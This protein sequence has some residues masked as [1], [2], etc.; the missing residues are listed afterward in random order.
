[1][2][3]I[4]K[5]F[6]SSGGLSPAFCDRLRSQVEVYHLVGRSLAVAHL[7]AAYEDDHYVYMV[8]ELCTGEPLNPNHG[9][10]ASSNLGTR[11]G[12]SG[13]SPHSSKDRFHT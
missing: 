7:E 8:Q 6:C 5:V 9:G 2:K 10:T 4:K 1:M 11:P 13:K 3:R 12:P